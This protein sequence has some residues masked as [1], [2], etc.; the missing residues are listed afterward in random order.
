[1]WDYYWVSHKKTWL[2]AELGRPKR[3][4]SRALYSHGKEKETHEFAGILLLVHQV[5][6]SRIIV[7]LFWT[8]T[9]L[10]YQISIVFIFGSCKKR[11]L[12]C[13]F[14]KTAKFW[15]LLLLLAQPP[16]ARLIFDNHVM[17]NWNPSKQGRR[18]PVSCDHIVGSSL[19]LTC[20]LK[21]TAD[22]VLLFNW[23]AGLCPVYLLKTGKDCLEVLTQDH[24]LTKL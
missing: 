20:C 15:L 17:I 5:L 8:T 19:Q 6:P 21:L 9:A 10:P 14:N 24:K 2:I 7:M 13:L 11:Q 18:W 1:M 23:I 22:K 16:Y 12:L 3:P 4:P